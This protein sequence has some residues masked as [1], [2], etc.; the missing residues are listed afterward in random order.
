MNQADDR[1]GVAAFEPVAFD[2]MVGQA[3]DDLATALHAFR[4]Q[5]QEILNHGSGFSRF[6]GYGGRR[7]DWTAVSEAALQAT[8]PRRFFQKQFQCFRVFERERSNGLFT[9]YYEPEVDGCRQ[10]SPDYP[11]P[12]LR[13]PTD[14]VVFTANEESRAGVKYGRRHNGEPRVYS[15]RRDIEQGAL[16]GQGLEIC[17][18][19][20][21]VEAF[22]MHIQG[23]GR[24]RL[25]EG[26]KIRLSYAAKTGLP[27]TGVGGV[28]ADRGILARDTLSMQTVKAWM[29]EHPEEARQLMWL[30]K[31]YVFFREIAVPDAGLGAVGAAQVNLTP[32][33][34]MAVDRAH[35]Q[36]G[37]PFWIE[38]QY[39][40]ELKAE[41]PAISRLMIAQDT[42][43]AIRGVV[44]GDFYWG[45]GD[46]AA[47]VA[48]HMKSPGR[49]TVLLPHA[50]AARLGLP[51]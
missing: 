27:Y 44:R 36:F 8:E 3:T 13:R 40:P 37:T 19:K 11:V 38:T 39:P 50:V 41:F 31:S 33:R 28:L 23:S 51:R 25:S 26:G 32:Q 30:N 10:A 49:M 7:E 47:E 21:W 4:R 20:S 42:G 22:F 1:T 35:W 48:G 9:G 15:E 24:V 5:A 45:W 6:P 18:L 17:W 14:L 29:N 46:D 16:A 12:I 43:T 34:S 2:A